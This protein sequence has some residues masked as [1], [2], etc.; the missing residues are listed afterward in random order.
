MKDI[1]NII[2]L[3]KDQNL[4]QKY[5]IADVSCWNKVNKIEIVI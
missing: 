4:T 3:L 5:F 1:L 2:I